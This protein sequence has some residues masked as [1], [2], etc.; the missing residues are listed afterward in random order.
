MGDDAVWTLNLLALPFKEGRID[1][2]ARLKGPGQRSEAVG[3]I[4][5]AQMA[6]QR[7][8]DTKVKLNVKGAANSSVT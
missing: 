2:S 1:H 7:L 8:S 4:V 5:E 3:K 6:K